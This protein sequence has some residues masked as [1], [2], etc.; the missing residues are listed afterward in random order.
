M[1]KWN[2]FIGFLLISVF[3]SSCGNE[4][5]NTPPVTTEENKTLHP[6]PKDVSPNEKK[7][8][9]PKEEAQ[10][11]EPRQ[12]QIEHLSKQ[13]H[14]TMV[15]EP[16]KK[17]Q[18]TADNEETKATPPINEKAIQQ[19]A[20]AQQEQQLLEKLR[21]LIKDEAWKTVKERFETAKGDLTAVNTNIQLIT[22]ILDNFKPLYRDLP[23]MDIK[24]NKEDTEE[25][26][27]MEEYEEEDFCPR[28]GDLHLYVN[29]LNNFTGIKIEE[30]LI[31][32][33]NQ[34]DLKKPNPLCGKKLE[35]KYDELQVASKLRELLEN[36]TYMHPFK[37]VNEKI[38][39]V[40]QNLQ[41]Q[42]IL[43]QTIP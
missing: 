30:S 11:K 3:I 14:P 34:L 9:K 1:K 5:D 19:Q 13:E 15:N 4:K 32:F 35:K 6:H 17:N 36:P 7:L 12:E 28:I 8:T 23:K 25:E 26:E 41:Q 18:T 43:N 10:Q 21:P 29:A 2:T 22:Q 42:A 38:L 39:A 24:G 27:D 33:L 16:E 20:L 40:Y 31:K 37:Q